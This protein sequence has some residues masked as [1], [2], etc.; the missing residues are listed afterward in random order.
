MTSLNVAI[1]AVFQRSLEDQRDT[2][3]ALFRS[4]VKQGSK[5]DPHAFAE[6]VRTRIGNNIAAIELVL[7]E[8]T[9]LATA[10]LYEVSLELFAAG[11]FGEGTRTPHLS[12]LWEWLLPKVAKQLARDPRQVAGC[13]SNAVVQIEQ[14]SSQAAE[15]WIRLLAQ[16]NPHAESVDELLVLGKVAAWVSGMSHFRR[17]ALAAASLL[18]AQAVASLFGLNPDTDESVIRKYL[19]QLDENP[20][21]NSMDAQHAREL[22]VRQVA[23]C[24]AFRGFGGSMMKP[25]SVATIDNK[26]MVSDGQHVWQIFADRFGSVIQRIDVEPF[27]GHRALAKSNPHVSAD[28]TVQWDRTTINRS[29][30]ANSTSF[31][32]DGTTLAVTIPASFHVFLFA[33][34]SVNVPSSHTKTGP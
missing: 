8:R 2:L 22:E 29:D 27:Q 23:I 12:M 25:P 21:C 16:T 15:R 11:H 26:L 32:F 13:L 30:L 6:H 4:R 14:Q 18:P 33:R 10:E 34:T 9:R 20:W 1:P 3:N 17:S 24:A 19:T 5:I 7:P 28:G 31:A